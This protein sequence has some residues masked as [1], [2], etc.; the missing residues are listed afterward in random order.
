MEIKINLSKV[1]NMADTDGAQHWGLTDE[2]IGAVMEGIGYPIWVEKKVPQKTKVYEKE[3]G[4]TTTDTAEAKIGGDG[5]KITYKKNGIVQWGEKTDQDGNIVYKTEKGS[6]KEY[7]DFTDEEVEKFD[8]AIKSIIEKYYVP[9][10][11][12]VKTNPQ[13]YLK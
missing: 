11:F 7:D 12:G 4:G 2:K 9:E 3:G 6:I 10:S 5:K 8:W 1:P 13:P